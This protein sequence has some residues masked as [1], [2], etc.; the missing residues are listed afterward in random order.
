ME[1]RCHGCKQKYNNI[2]KGKKYLKW[3]DKIKRSYHWEECEEIHAAKELRGVSSHSYFSSGVYHGR[4]FQDIFFTSDLSLRLKHEIAN[5]YDRSYISNKHT[6]SEC[7]PRYI[8]TITTAY[9]SDIMK[10]ILSHEN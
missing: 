6:Y 10:G 2:Y 3:T 7:Q 4:G 1:G 9:H 8:D 5:E